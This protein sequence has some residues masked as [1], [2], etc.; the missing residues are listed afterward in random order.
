MSHAYLVTM[1][2]R[3]DVTLS[4]DSIQI[5]EYDLARNME[6][7]GRASNSSHASPRT[8]EHKSMSSPLFQD[9]FINEKTKDRA[10]CTPILASV[11]KESG[12]RAFAGDLDK[13][14]KSKSNIQC[15]TIHWIT[16]ESKKH[17][18]IRQEHSRTGQGST[19][20]QDKGAQLY[21][22]REHSC[23]GQET[24]LYRTREHS[25]TG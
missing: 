22:T 15:C 13:T 18:C 3:K 1:V 16:K 21:R 11:P 24:Q 10:V 23:T 7:G 8:D 12:F 25:C 14:G 19:A 9:L 20:V 5:L 17:S 4:T 2:A 6:P